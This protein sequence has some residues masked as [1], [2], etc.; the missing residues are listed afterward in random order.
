M[1]FLDRLVES[2][3]RA[4][5]EASELVE[6][7]AT[8]NRDLTAEEQEKF[9][10]IGA[11]L[12]AKDTEIRSWTERL[13]RDAEND[14]ARSE[15]AQILK[16]DQVERSTVE[17]DEFARFVRGEGGKSFD[18]DF[19]SIAAEKAAIRAG[20]SGQDFRDL[21]KVTTTAG[22]YTV[23]TFLRQLYDYLEVYSGVRRLGVTVLTTT[24]GESIDVPTVTSHGTA[25]IVG[26]GTALAEADPAFGKITLGAY[27][28]GQLIQVSSELLQDTGVDLLGFLARDLGRALGRATDTAYVTGT[29]SNAPEGLAAALGTG[30]TAQTAATGLPSY[31][32]L[33]DMIYSVNEEY[34]ANGAQWFMKDATLGALRKLVDTTN[35]PLWEPSLQLG[36]PDRFMGYAVV[37][38]PNVAALGTASTKPIMF[39]D[40]SGFFIRDVGNIRVERSDEFAFSS[41]LVSWRAIMRTDSKLVDKTGCAKL[42]LEPTT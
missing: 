31:A 41:D 40:F 6:R 24:G 17:V 2:R 7:A 28:Y 21:V 19:R 16:T 23:P 27:K 34:R 30:A 32:N 26:E 22:G 42:L 12:D 35:R 4:W 29:G 15:W 1:E 14:K 18:L 37:T 3:A 8:E 25:A 5:N 10:R 33:V 11:D 39:G 9:D 36:Q 13:E 20:A 38:D